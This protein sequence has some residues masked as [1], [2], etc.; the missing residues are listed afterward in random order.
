M[1]PIT[2]EYAPD[3]MGFC[4]RCVHAGQRPNPITR[5]ILEPVHQCSV[6][7]QTAPGDFIHDYGR[8]MSP[9]YTPVEQ[10][11]GALEE[12]TFATVTS[13]G[14]SA[15][16]AVMTLLSSGDRVLIPTDVYGG[17]YRLFMQIFSR[18][19]INFTS[20]DMTD[21]S[22]VDEA[23]KQGCKLLYTESPSN[24]LLKIYDLQALCTLA[25]KYGALAAIDNTFASPYFQRPLQ[26]GFDV[27]LHSASK[28]LGGHGDIVAGVLVTDNKS[29]KDS[30]DFSRKAMGLHPDP[31]TLFLLRRSLKTLGLRMQRHESNALAV[32][33]FLETHPKVERVLYPGLPTHPQHDLAKRQ[34]RGFSGMLSVYL[35]LPLEETKRLVSSFQLITLAESLGA[36]DSLVEH[37]ASMT[38]K[39]IPSDVR[40]KH[41]LGEGLIRFSIG[42][43]DAADLIKDIQTVLG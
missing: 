3:E 31:Q 11:L 15:I 7:A 21:L 42:L 20:V 16:T 39:W 26:F 2:K 19:A 36:A 25:K 24:P 34:M 35:A 40:L 17:T 18:Y 8:S 37:P 43:E 1:K 9:S 5:A 13:S 6:F 10:A 38:H 28:Y 27:V 41:G 23:L 33:H 14:V 30:F 22:A 32:A 12:G 29:L 4:T